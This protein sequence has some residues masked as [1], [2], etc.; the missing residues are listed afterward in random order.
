MNNVR[1]FYNRHR[2]E[3]DQRLEH[4]ALELPVT[5]KY[6]DKYLGK[7]ARVLDVACGTGWY[8]R[9]LIERGYRVS[10][11]DLSERNVALTLQRTKGEGALEHVAISDALHSD[12]WSKE[13]WDAVLLLGPLYHLDDYDR[14]L[15]LLRKAGEYVASGGYVYSAF[16]SRTSA[17]VFGLQTNPEGIR[18]PDG[19]E[20]LWETGSDKEFVEATDWFTKG[21]FSFP[22][23]VDPLIRDAGLTPLHLVGIEGIFGERMDLFLN[24]DASL[25]NDWREFIMRHCEDRHMVCNSKHLLS[26]S[27]H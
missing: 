2:P 16:M 25:Q 23:E 27:R 18:H 7:G 26:V 20:K 10:V 14:R 19:A 22:E 3:E 4:N 11:N 15:A 6:I 24:L 13:A 9:A 8:A 12:V 5:M 21:Y 1:A 17:M